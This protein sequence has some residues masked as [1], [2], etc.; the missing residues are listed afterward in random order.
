MSFPRGS[1]R[2]TA[3]LVVLIV[4]LLVYGIAQGNPYAYIMAGV[5]FVF[6]AL[7]ALLIVG[8]NRRHQSTA[9]PSQPMTDEDDQQALLNGHHP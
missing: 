7:P 3:L 8:L 2:L 4:G 5:L 6:G 9:A 1:Y